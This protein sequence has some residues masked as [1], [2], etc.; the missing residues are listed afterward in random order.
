[1]GGGERRETS[2][3][4][5]LEG[6]VQKWVRREGGTWESTRTWGFRTVIGSVEELGDGGD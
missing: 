1:M 6:D 4:E 2:A 5:V 3:D